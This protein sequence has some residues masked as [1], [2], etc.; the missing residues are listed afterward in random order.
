MKKERV[1]PINCASNVVSLA[2]TGAGRG[3]FVGIRGGVLPSSPNPDTISDRK[4]VT[5]HTRFQNRGP[6]LESPESFWGPESYLVFAIF[7][8]KI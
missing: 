5:F 1:M 4:I 6:F 8:F 3:L 2:I 7:A